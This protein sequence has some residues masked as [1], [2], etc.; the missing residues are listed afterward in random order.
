M[1]LSL[2]SLMTFITILPAH[3]APYGLALRGNGEAAPA[4]WG[5]IAAVV[6]EL[7]LP[8]KQA[9]GSSAVISMMLLDA[10]AANSWVRE[11]RESSGLRAA[12]LIKSLSGLTAYLLATPE[13]QAVSATFQA[14]QGWRALH[15]SEAE[16][17]LARLQTPEGLEEVL[18]GLGPRRREFLTTLQTLRQLGLEAGTR[19]ARA[20]AL[21]EA[22]IPNGH[23]TSDQS[24]EVRFVMQDLVDAIRKLGAFD[25]DNDPNLFFREGLVNFRTLG[26]RAG[27]VASFLAGQINGAAA[28]KSYQ[29]FLSTCGTPSTR[30]RT[31]PEIVTAAPACTE[32]LNTAFGLYL[33]DVPMSP[34]SE[35][36]IGQKI[37]SFPSTAVLAGTAA[38]DAEDTFARYAARDRDAAAR[39]RP[40]PTQ[41]FFGYWGPADDL[42]RIQK[43]FK[44]PFRD[45]EGVVRDYTRDAKSTRFL[46]LGLARWIDALATSPAE[47][48]LASLQPFRANG[49]TLYSAGGWSDLHPV[50]VLRA[51]GSDRV[52]YITRQGP[53]SKFAK[54]IARRLI[55]EH[56]RELYDGSNPDSALA[57]A[58]RE[59][60][61]I[62][63]T[64][65]DHFD[66]K[67]QLAAMVE[68]AYRAPLSQTCPFE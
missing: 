50:Q 23:L 24:A 9:G 39:F 68:N 62:K 18:R 56:T 59:A 60:D 52:V 31:W 2:L 65:W 36:E 38:R 14:L 53:D 49:E 29:E 45:T 8:E 22:Q 25:A 13:G 61:L 19:V 3:A 26:S 33:R 37:T 57:R 40:D 41:V 34:F 6:E 11:T 32:R 43:N 42:S 7:G 46:R 21:L 47:P 28:R 15:G 64:D 67:S 66:V 10:T 30:G 63:C 12:F 27:V 16:H 17:T 54:A 58:M 35:F 51:S 1:H 44:Q 20:L 55:G 5:A 4:H 48:G